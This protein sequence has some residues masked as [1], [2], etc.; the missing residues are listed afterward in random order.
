MKTEQIAKVCHEANRAYCLGLGDDTQK[1]WEESP[2]W[3]RNSAIKGVRF[4]IKNP[5]AS[6][7]ASH[8]EWLK[9]KQS[10]GWKYGKIKDVEKKTHPCFVPYDKLPKK[11]QKKDALFSAII[12]A[13]A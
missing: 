7:S 13:L 10:E 11:Q 9:L 1:P 8:D 6:Q 2:E 4:H 12:K 5:E 3:Q